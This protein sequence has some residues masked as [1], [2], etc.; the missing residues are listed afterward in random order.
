[1][2][3][4]TLTVH[5]V[6]Q[7]TAIMHALKLVEPVATPLPTIA[8][9]VNE[10]VAR[11]LA[12]E[13]AMADTVGPAPAAKAEAP[14]KPSAAPTARSPRTAEAAPSPSAPSPAA[15]ETSE[16]PSAPTTAPVAAAPSAG[17]APA[18]EYATLQKAVN[19]RV[20]KLGKDKLLAVAA[21]HGAKTFKELPADKWQ[22]AYEDVIALGV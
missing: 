19:E 11:Q 3:P 9:S 20:A 17:D 10:R 21:K 2:F 4:L 14:G 18:F 8:A 5:N 7:L 12:T 1:M 16:K 22:A 15:P 6:D 13:S